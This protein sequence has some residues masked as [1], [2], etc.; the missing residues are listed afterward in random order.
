ADQWPD[1]DNDRKGWL[2]LRKGHLLTVGQFLISFFFIFDALEKT[3]W[4]KTEAAKK[5]GISFRSI[6]YRLNKLGL[7][8]D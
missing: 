3:R 1:N 2:S 8:D 7:N 6:R 5:L 4:N